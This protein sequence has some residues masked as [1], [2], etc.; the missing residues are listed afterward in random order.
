MDESIF[1]EEYWWI[2][3][4]CW[5]NTKDKIIERRKSGTGASGY[6]HNLEILNDKAENYAKNTILKTLRSM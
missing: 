6:M 4:R 2:I 5:D 1:V 3:L